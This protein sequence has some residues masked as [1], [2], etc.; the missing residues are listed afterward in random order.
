MCAVPPGRSCTVHPHVRGDDVRLVK[1]D[2]ISGGPPPRAWGRRHPLRPS[3]PPCTVHPHVRGDDFVYGLGMAAFDRSTPTCVGTTSSAGFCSRSACGPPPRAWGRRLIRRARCRSSSVHPHV[4]GDDTSDVTVAVPTE[5]STPT[6]VGTTNAR[7]MRSA[8]LSVHP[9]VRGDDRERDTT[10]LDVARSTPTCVGTTRERV[11]LVRN[12]T[13][14]PH[15]RGDDLQ[16]Y[17]PC[18]A[19][20]RSTPTC[21]GTTLPFAHCL[22]DS[23]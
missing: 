7:V 15:V 18:L 22:R 13:V 21:V 11:R 14:H 8:A 10:G 16:P 4:R 23:D 5:R 19:G 2:T 9:H 12:L 3:R 6:C 20:H 17:H 1:G